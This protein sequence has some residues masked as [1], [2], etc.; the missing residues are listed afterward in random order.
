MV[1]RLEWFDQHDTFNVEVSS[2]TSL[3]SGATD[4]D[5]VDCDQAEEVGERIQSHFMV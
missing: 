5:M 1:K 2:L 3:S 4:E